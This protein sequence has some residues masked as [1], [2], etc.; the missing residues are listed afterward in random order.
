MP[1]AAREVNHDDGFVAVANTGLCFGGEELRECQGANSANLN[2]LATRN[3]ITESPAGC[4]FD[5]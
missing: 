1:D 3:A 2:E 4:P 5:T